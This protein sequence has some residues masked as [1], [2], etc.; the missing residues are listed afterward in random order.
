MVKDEP[1]SLLRQTI[2]C[3]IPILD[4][5]AAYRVKHLRWYLVIMILGVGVP[6]SIIAS[7][8]FPPDESIVAGFA[9]VMMFYYGTND[10]RFEFS[11]ISHIVTVLVAISLIR[12]WSQKWNEKFS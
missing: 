5:Y 6:T 9:N 8:L 7:V 12:Y 10:G 4:I 2:Y 1:V 3:L 11:I